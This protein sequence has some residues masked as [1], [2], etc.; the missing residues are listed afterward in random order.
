MT[1]KSIASVDPWPD[2]CPAIEDLTPEE[3]ISF[4]DN[5][6]YAP[7]NL[8]EQTFCASIKDR[9]IYGDDLTDRQMEVLG[10]M[11]RHLYDSDPALWGS[12][13]LMLMK[14]VV[15]FDKVFLEGNEIYK[16]NHV[17]ASDWLAFWEALS[18]HD[19]HATESMNEKIL[20]A[21]QEISLL[22][23]TI[24]DLKLQ[25]AELREKLSRYES[26]D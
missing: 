1:Y 19:P 21:N 17:S 16:P 26:E 7:L 5:A 4:L 15:D 10:N 18:E 12:Y 8:W 3:L 2:K 23:E 25:I 13:K 20:A 6:D 22:E 9:L 14:I 11:L 24:T